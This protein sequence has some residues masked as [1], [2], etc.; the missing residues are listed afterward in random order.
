[1]PTLAIPYFWGQITITAGTNDRIDWAEDNGATVLNLDT[2]VPAGT[3]WPYSATASESLAYQIANALTL[4]SA[5]SGY[6]GSYSVNVEDSSVQITAAGGT[7]AGFYLKTS[8]AE[9]DKL[10][11]GGDVDEGE[12]GA[13][14]Y[15]WIVDASGVYPGDDLAFDSDTIPCNCWHP[16][17]PVTN[18]TVV[19]GDDLRYTSGVSQVETLGGRVVVRDFSGAIAPNQVAYR[20]RRVLQTNF[21]TD[22]D[23]ER[24]VSQFWLPYA[25]TG[26]KIRY[27][28][29]KTQ[30]DDYEERHLFGDSLST[31]APTR[32]PGYPYFDLTIET[33]L[34]KA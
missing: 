6:S 32:L 12:Q 9:S 20:E 7:L 28:P 5:A 21:L 17:G 1:V 16:K 26:A 11:T 23:R 10:L 31:L 24:Y 15:G 14:H 3:Y 34:W 27:I 29:D 8:T 25:K 2:T 33:K 4:E 18:T 30:P 13:N 22:D 19:A